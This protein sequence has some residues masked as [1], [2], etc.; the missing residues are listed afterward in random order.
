MSFCPRT[1]KLGILKFSKLG[2]LQL[3]RAITSYANLWLRWGLKQS[4]IPCQKLSNGMWHATCM[5]V[6]EGD[7]QLLVVGSQIGTLTSDLSFNHN[8]CFKYLNGSCKPILDIY[9]SRDFQWYKNFFNPM[10]FDLWNCFLKLRLQFL[11]WE[12]IW[13]CVGSFLHTLLH[14]RE[15]EMWILSFTFDLHLCKPLHWLQAQG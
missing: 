11:K 2:F 6:N 4:Y 12:P 15:H 13:E 9:V 14:S 7:Y 3:W 1:P 5:Q 10:N 8:L